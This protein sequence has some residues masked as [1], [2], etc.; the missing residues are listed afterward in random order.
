MEV[1]RPPPSPPVFP[2]ALFLWWVYPASKNLH[3]CLCRQASSAAAQGSP[4]RLLPLRSPVPSIGMCSDA[5]APPRMLRT[6]QGG[7]LRERLSNDP[8]GELRWYCKGKGGRRQRGRGLRRQGVGARF[9]QV[10]GMQGRSKCGNSERALSGHRCS[11][12]GIALDCVRGL[13]VLHA[14][15]CIHR[16]VK[17]GVRVG[18][19]RSRLV[20][21]GYH[22]GL[23]PSG[24]PKA[25][26]AS[27]W[28]Q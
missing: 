15:S 21:A 5:T 14:S 3:A 2:A 24:G 22:G 18:A 20:P 8:A 16:D 9:G 6:L 27:P 13:H 12:V 4:V 23:L 25:A 7:D 17:S 11:S 28:L 1:G 10:W 19:W 26:L